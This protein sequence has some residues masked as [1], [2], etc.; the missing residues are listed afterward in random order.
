MSSRYED[1]ALQPARRLFRIDDEREPGRIVHGR[2]TLPQAA[3]APL[4]WVLMLHGFKGFMD[5]GFFPELATRLAQVGIA[6]VGFNTSASG[7]G[8]DLATFTELA[9]FRRGTLSRQLE[10][11]ERVRAEVRS[12]ALGALDPARGAVF[13]HSRGGGMALL[14]ASEAGDYRAVVTWAAL[15]DFDRW[16]EATKQIW[17][18]S[19]EI[20]VMH[21]R[22]GQE[23]PIGVEVL[24]D[25]ERNRERFDLLAACRRLRAPVLALHGSA[26][27]SVEPESLDRIADALPRD[28]GSR[29]QLLEGQGHTFGAQHP[30]VSIPQALAGALETTVEWFERHLRV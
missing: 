24:E 10:D 30:L 2:V 22:T 14:H 20:R 11:I 13:G 26:D 28:R 3:L 21:A 12:G 19:G 9:A 27:E 8:E 29:A 6:T 16:D 18:R 1:S 4:P 17:R 15:S 5:W 23:L 7:V 25:F